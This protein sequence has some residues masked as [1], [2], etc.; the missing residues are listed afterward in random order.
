MSS[1][2]ARRFADLLTRDKRY[3]L[4]AYVFVGEAL[5]YAQKV[6]GLGTSRSAPP[7]NPKQA[8]PAGEGSKSRGGREPKASEES[9]VERHVTGQQLCEAIRVYALEQ[10]GLMAKCVLNSWGVHCTGDFGE[11]VF[12]LIGIEQMRKTDEDRREDFDDVF[13]FDEGLSG[14]FRISLPGK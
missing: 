2:P 6:L 4:E 14:S 5:D 3:K 8:G 9:G 7:E 1:D 10:Y 12:N 11:I 13:D